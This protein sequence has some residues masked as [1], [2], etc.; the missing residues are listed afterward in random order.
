MDHPSSFNRCGPFSRD[1]GDAPLHVLELPE[2]TWFGV[3][4]DRCNGFRFFTPAVSDRGPILHWHGL[5]SRIRRLFSQQ[6]ACQRAVICRN[7]VAS[8]IISR[9]P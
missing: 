1:C 6:R 8:A 3:P 4:I 5:G 7:L 2:D 9:S